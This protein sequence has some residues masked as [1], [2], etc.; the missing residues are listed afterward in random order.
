[1]KKMECPIKY[2]EGNLYFNTSSLGSGV[3]AAYKLDG[4]NYAFQTNPT[5]IQVLINQVQLIKSV[6]HMKILVIP[7][8]EDVE[9]QRDRVLLQ[10]RE[11]DVLAEDAKQH[12]IGQTEYLKNQGKQ[13]WNEYT[14]YLLVK[15]EE[16]YI[17]DLEMATAVVKEFMK[18]PINKLTA[19]FG[20]EKDD[21]TTIDYHKAK[22]AERRTYEVISSF[23]GM[24]PLTSSETQ[25]LLKRVNYRGTDKPVR[26][27]RTITKDNNETTDEWFPDLEEGKL[28]KV[29]Y[30]RPYKQD[31]ANIFDGILSKNKN[32]GIKI[33]HTDGVTSYQSYLVITN[34]PKQYKY[35]GK[36]WIYNLKNLPMQ[37]EMCIDIENVHFKV[38][39]EQ[40]EK[41]NIEVDT[42]IDNVIEAGGKE[43][44]R[45]LREVKREIPALLDELK[46]NKIPMSK[47]RISICL[48]ADCEETIENNILKLEKYFKT[49]DFTIVR[50]GADQVNL[51]L[52]HI[53]G[54]ETFVE[55]FTLK[56]SPFVIASGVFGAANR[57]G[58]RSGRYIGMADGK[59]CYSNSAQAALDNKSPAS[60]IWGKL[61]VGK[62]FNA[63]L[64][65]ALD[66]MAGAYGIVI[67]PKG[68]RKNW[69][70]MPIIG[71]YVKK[72][73]LT[74]AEENRGKLDPYNIYNN[75][76][77][78]A[79]QLA[80][81][82]ITELLKINNGSNEETVLNECISLLKKEPKRNMKRLVELIGSVKKEDPFYEDAYKLSRR[83]KSKMDNGYAKLLFGD[84]S[85]E[86]VSIDG[87]VNVI[88]L[89][90]VS[91]PT[92]DVKKE[93]YDEEQKIAMILMLVISSFIRKFA[94]MYPN[95]YKVALID[96]S[97]AL[98]SNPKGAEMMEWCNRQCRSLYFGPTYN[99]HSVLDLPNEK[100]R[101]TITY[102][103]CFRIED[104]AEAIRSLEFL[105][106]DPSEENINI[107][108]NLEN[109]ECL[110]SDADG[111]VARLKFD[112]VYQDFVDFFK[113]TPEPKLSIAEKIE[114]DDTLQTTQSEEQRSGKENEPLQATN[115]HNLDDDQLL[116]MLDEVIGR[117]KMA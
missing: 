31:I 72:V 47:V 35:P 40:L 21:I 85:E 97:W 46:E 94:L 115:A 13:Y 24:K 102:K 33:E 64:M 55:C 57:V 51:Y 80:A 37:S 5:K 16:S 9:K 41:K 103:Y 44:P 73:E 11:D 91:F 89:S 34:I 71:P 2:F 83:L 18:E 25:W 116:Q 106:L 23:L 114:S 90:G 50:P 30:K 6:S 79:G 54:T 101:N 28:G 42:Q 26:L 59:P 27:N 88:M 15:L 48:S 22:E 86:A 12:V 113:T 32:K 117:E 38:A 76:V 53:P 74:T 8:F 63:N 45:E 39:Q 49:N 87:R 112:A 111:R 7:T 62:T 43:I 60:Y 52:Q 17:N 75:D 78:Y 1:M 14:T 65:F 82:V 104:R 67:C 95:I 107:L 81:M 84:G 93:D 98:S 109:A 66:I 99:A 19:W 100:L 110:Y 29:E 56:L 77:E 20:L 70:K 105:K 68:E 58:D 61:G 108:G 92:A 4:Y 10:I 69:D 36:E 96:E 3:W